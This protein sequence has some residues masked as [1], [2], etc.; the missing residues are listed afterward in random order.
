MN[1]GS[2]TDPRTKLLSRSWHPVKGVTS[3]RDSRYQLHQE[4]IRSFME[5]LATIDFI[6]NRAKRPIGD[7]VLVHP[8]LK[9]EL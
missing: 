4:Q 5:Y 3:Q 9:S 7:E 8:E 1:F 6:K 2:Q